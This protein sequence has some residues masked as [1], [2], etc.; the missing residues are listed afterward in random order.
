MEETDLHLSLQKSGKEVLWV[1]QA[2]VWQESGGIPPFYFARNI[3]ILLRKHGGFI[4]SFAVPPLIVARRIA[5]DL[6]RRRG[7]DRVKDYLRGLVAPIPSAGTTPQINRSVHIINPLGAALLHYER[8]L[9]SVL[10]EAGCTVSSA[11]FSEPS[12]GRESPIRWVAKY[13]ETL[14]YA[15]FSL[16]KPSRIVITWPV[17][18]Y[19]DIVLVG[20]LGFRNVAVVLHDP[21]PLVRSVGYSD[22]AKRFASVF[23]SRVQIVAHSKQA[24]E[25]ID[26]VDYPFSVAVLPHPIL[27]P[28]A[29][30]RRGSKPLPIVRVLGQYKA[31]RDLQALQDLSRDLSLSAI[32]EVHGRGWPAIEGW[33]V[34]DGFV[35]EQKLD[36]L[37]AES[38]AVLIPY[39]RFFQSGIAVRALEVGTPFVGPRESVLAEMLGN[40]S[41]LL[42][43]SESKDGWNRAVTY[44]IEGG[45]QAAW[46]AGVGW[47]ERNIREW[48]AW[49]EAST[50]VASSE[51]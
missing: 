36:A 23:R 10:H 31:D 27:P 4:R 6:V 44:A 42:V 17:L 9:T 34:I 46:R 47:R 3:R 2:R 50:W 38:A 45:V 8:E 18:G 1:P 51:R 12:A 41:G 49:I 11:R 21:E 30:L 35:E 20:L 26:L 5:A 13:V 33:T 7:F 24:R 29:E 43:D 39:K 37:M 25:A 16:N 19:L 22:V 28:V 40:E 14:V 15:R 32:F 48:S